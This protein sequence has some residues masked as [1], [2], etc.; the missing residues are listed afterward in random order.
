MTLNF[1][2][3]SFCFI[4]N[5]LV[6][7]GHQFKA[8]VIK[9]YDA[10]TGNLRHQWQ[11]QC[12]HFLP[13]GSLATCIMHSNAEYLV[14]GCPRKRCQVIRVYDLENRRVSVA[15]VNIRPIHICKG[16]GNSLLVSS[17]KSKT[18]LQLAKWE[19]EDPD[20]TFHASH[21]VAVDYYAEKLHVMNYT[22]Y[23]DVVI[24]VTKETKQIIAVALATGVTVWKHDDSIGDI[25]LKPIDV[26]TAPDGWICVA[27]DNRLVAMDA[28]NGRILKVLQSD[29]LVPK[30]LAASGSSYIAVR[31]GDVAD[32]MS[33]Y[34]I[35]QP[36]TGG[37]WSR[38]LSLEE[39][40]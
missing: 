35:T 40:S 17:W 14:E 33:F 6:V 26:C 19:N 5:Q 8:K 9:V 12:Q 18:I 23:G 16:P 24:L 22:S 13:Y 25:R 20:L 21:M 38:D 3:N 37:V 30:R 31:H 36:Y 4:G 34:T 15:Y 32:K 39:V 7:R 27:N 11:P 1:V 29:I 2:P 10:E 28:T